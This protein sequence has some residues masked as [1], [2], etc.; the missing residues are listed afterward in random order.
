MDEQ[1]TAG[2]EIMMAYLKGC[3]IIDESID[4]KQMAEN[5]ISQYNDAMEGSL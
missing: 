3:D 5:A 4:S 1:L 2:A